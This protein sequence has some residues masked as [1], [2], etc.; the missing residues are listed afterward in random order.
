MKLRSMRSAE[1]TR[2]RR[3]VARGDGVTVRAVVTHM[4]GE[5]AEVAL[6]LVTPV[7]IGSAVVRNR[8]RRR[9]RALVAELARAGDL[10]PGQ[11]IVAFS[12]PPPVTAAEFRSSVE[13]LL[14]RAA[15]HPA[16]TRR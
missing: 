7:K 14:R 1:F 12:A 8:A 5:S 9:T 11:Y 10:P 3:G 4:G 16:A 13:P 2:R 6:G 15:Q